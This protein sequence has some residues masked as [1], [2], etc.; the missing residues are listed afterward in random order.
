MFCQ[1][2]ENGKSWESS[3]RSTDLERGYSSSGCQRDGSWATNGD[4]SYF[5]TKETKTVY[6]EIYDVRILFP[7]PRGYQEEC[8]IRV[9]GSN[10][11]LSFRGQ[12]GAVGTDFDIAA[13]TYDIDYFWFLPPDTRLDRLNEAIDLEL[14]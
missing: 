14:R 2:C 6:T 5:R 11:P 10:P 8:K 9:E 4:G 13:G 3:Q 12:Y 1:V 7:Y